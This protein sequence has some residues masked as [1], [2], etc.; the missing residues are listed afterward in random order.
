[1][2]LL[3]LGAALQA[4]TQTY[5]ALNGPYGGSPKKIISAGANLLAIMDGAGVLKSSDN[6][7]TWTTSN[8]GITDLN[9]RD[10]TRDASSGK[11]YAIGYNRLFTSTD[12]GNNWTLTA[13]SG[14]TDTRFIRKTASFLF[15]IGYQ[16]VYRSSNDGTSWSQINSFDG[17]PS[18]F[19]VNSSGYFFI[20]TW[21]N[22]VYRSTNN[23]LNLDQRIPNNSGTDYNENRSLVV[24]GTSIYTLTS[25]GPFKSTNNGDTWILSVGVA[26]NNLPPCCFGWDTRIIEKDPSG[27]IYIFV[28][29]D[30][31]KSTD[32]AASWSQLGSV[33]SGAWAPPQAAYFQSA[34]TFMVGLENTGLYGTT[35]GGASW[36]P[37]SN[38]GIAGFSPEDFTMTSNGRL[39]YAKGW[40]QGF[41][42]SIDDGATWDFL[43]TGV[44][45]KQIS[46]FLKSGTDVFAYGCGIIKSIDN[47]SNWTEIKDCEYYFD[48]LLTNDGTNIMSVNRDYSTSPPKYSILKSNNAG[49]NWTVLPINGMSSPDESY[50]PEPKK[51]VYLSAGGNIFVRVYEYTNFNKN[52]L[53]KVDPSTGNATE[54]VSLPTTNYIESVSF[55]NGK[56]Y[57]LTSNAKL[58]ISS[59]AG[60][61]WA[62]KNTSTS[63]GR[64]QIIGDNTFYI[65]NNSI[66]LSTDGGNTWVNTGDPSGAGGNWYRSAL[67]SSANY[68]YIAK[69][70]GVVYKSINQVIP[71][72]A[73]S[74]LASYGYDRNSVGLIWNDNSANEN[75][76]VIEA[77]EGDNLNYDSVTYATRPSSWTRAQGIA[78]VSSINGASLKNNTTYFFRV[79]ASGSGGKSLPSNEISITTLVD[80]TSTSVFPFNRSWTATTLN[81]S[82]IGVKT[83]LDQTLTGSG[84]NY[85]IQD[86][87]IG[88]NTGLSPQ[89]PANW[90][91]G[92]EENCGSAFISSV[93]YYIANGNGTWN[94]TT[95]TLTIPWQTHPQYPLRTETTVYT[96]NATDP[97][98]ATP[99]NFAATVYLPGQILLNWSSG[100]FTQL[101]EL[102]RS[103]TSGGGF[104]KIADINFPT[105][106]Y[107]DA[108]AALVAGTTY[109]YRIR[110]KNT[111]GT[112]GY[113]TEVNV[114]PRSNYLFNPINNTPLLTFFQTG[115]GG[116]WGDIDGDGII[117]LAL[118]VVSDSTGNNELPPQFFKGDGTGKLSKISIPELQDEVAA[119]RMINI[120]DVNNDGLNDIYLSRSNTYDLLLIKNSNGSYTKNQITDISV[121]SKGIAGSS[122]TD[123]DNDGD[124]DLLITSRTVTTT[125]EVFLYEND[126]TGQLTRVTTGD[127]VTDVS[128]TG[129][130]EWADYDNDGDQDVLVVNQSNVPCRLYR[131]NGDGTLTRVLNS[132]FETN[133]AGRSA[134]WGDYDND[135]DLDAFVSSFTAPYGTL[136]RNQGDGTFV[137]SGQVFSEDAGSAS[138]TAGSAWADLD[139]DQDLDLIISG[140]TAAIFYNDGSGNFSKYATPELFNALNLNKFYGVAVHDADG[141]G[142]LDFHAGGFSNPEIPNII[143]RNT[144]AVS[145]SRKW[146]KFK[147]Q[148]TVSNRSAIGARVFLTIGATTQ[149]RELQS[150][151]GHT[152]Q[153][154]PVIHFGAGSASNIN[155][156]RIVWPSGIE[157]NL[158]NVAPN[159]TISIVEDGDAP[160]I[161]ALTPAD[162]ANVVPGLNQLS[163]K[164]DEVPFAVSGK[165]IKVFQNGNAAPIATI[166]AASGTKTDSTYT[167]S[168]AAINTV[169]SYYVQI[170]PFAFDDQWGNSHGGI[171]DV[172]TWSFNIIDVTPPAI[173]FTEVTTFDKGLGST[174]FTIGVTDAGGA[175]SAKM[176]Y[177]KIGSSQPFLETGDTPIASEKADFTVQ[178]SW[179][180]EMG[181]EYYFT[182]VDN[183]ENPGRFPASGSFHCYLKLTGAQAPSLPNLSFGGE[184][185]NYRIFSIPYVLV[186]NSTTSLFNSVGGQ[187]KTKWRLL[188]YKASPE[189]WIDFPSSIERGKGYFIN[190]VDP[191][192]IALGDATAP[193]N[194][195]N[196]PFT[197]SLTQG[198]NLIGNPYTF[199]VKWS[200]VVAANPTVVMEDPLF[201]NGSYVPLTQIEKFQGAFV[202]AEAA[203]TITIPVFNAAGGR[204]GSGKTFSSRIGE[205]E[206]E[207]PLT[208]T[209]GKYENAL[210]AI[211]MHTDAKLSKDRYDRVTPPRMF[212]Y[213]ELNFAHPEYMGGKNFSK[214]IVTTS[215]EHEWKFNVASN[216][217]GTAILGWNNQDLGESSKEL[218]LLDIARQQL[219]N[220]RETNSY[221]FQ[222]NVSNEFKVYFGEDVRS[223]IKP[224]AILLGNA[225]PNP[226]SGIVTIPFTLPKKE[227]QYGV[228]IEVY[229]NMGRK[230][231]TLLDKTLLPDFYTVQWNG[232]ELTGGLYTYR[233]IVSDK[234]GIDIQAGKIVLK[235]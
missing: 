227:P 136:F 206:W 63:Y 135:G 72:T 154:S 225:Y 25:A 44:T 80:C 1:M 102:E 97:V 221:A 219:V 162:D 75:G 232:N 201:F 216:L 113:S 165:K 7:S 197:I 108:D 170:D 87:P 68:S 158:Y 179:F 118:P 11:L 57:V 40:P 109:Y 41:L 169:D 12:N 112:S 76:F 173:T 99:T 119:T 167:Y 22:G 21:G 175:A 222:P 29:I 18:D 9:L 157:Q 146:I 234:S 92:F 125:P 31:W 163:I 144:T 82:G 174:T 142:F 184:V 128:F 83:A 132:A 23:G 19:E 235:K 88:A 209:Q 140:A 111:T 185:S 159:Q 59:D 14:F 137:D 114:I 86:L 74:G 152:T 188:S 85:V 71:P 160:V 95:N 193:T 54:I 151:T 155:Q 126:G 139:N 36:G 26:P 202:F 231:T 79:R 124:L 133:V 37:L 53:Y 90:A 203:A 134:S 210:G 62:T 107:K 106:A 50:I 55:F 51:D 33:L 190:I 34:S 153:S 214:E 122:W 182:A 100:N 187:D 183:A 143:Y 67:I 226:S 104:V 66:F 3:I 73:P 164:F 166:D 78:V 15:I 24:S 81:Q 48:N 224:T 4:H 93:N 89:P 168:I 212:E 178:E 196:S 20:S 191:V 228:K 230:V 141:D 200:D 233:L 56:L 39:L 192:E 61:T 45:D 116:T 47:G 123:Y 208:L 121:V 38:N 43:S 148:G 103:T 149:M 205:S 16:T 218:Y 105:I 32:G 171:N 207:L 223:K 176:H 58:H 115:G 195:Q 180:D 98:P 17:D 217:K 35:D 42:I 117:D 8:T 213:L 150:H 215:G 156:V 198:F 49:L 94:P 147:L 189:A 70:R 194:N 127:L 131:N 181:M 220:M 204:V 110:A 69:E 101:F 46:G 229:D 161:T 30:V 60:Q 10:I 145:A 129:D 177:K 96:L 138:F 13:N 28:G 27:N 84:G 77:S 120:V 172:T 186:N 5:T 52:L 65:L 64:L 199:N 91:V 6:G 130:A 2:S 211:G